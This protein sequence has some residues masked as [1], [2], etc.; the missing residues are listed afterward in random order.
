VL[1]VHE[2]TGTHVRNT[3]HRRVR[4]YTRHG[5][6]V[7]RT[8]LYRVQD[9]DPARV[10]CCCRTVT[11]SPWSARVRTDLLLPY[12]PRRRTVFG[13]ARSKNVV[14]TARGCVVTGNCRPR[15]PRRQPETGF[16]DLNRVRTKA[17]RKLN[18]SKRMKTKRSD[19]TF[20]ASVN[21]FS[22]SSVSG[23]GSRCARCVPAAN[24]VSG[25]HVFRLS[26]SATRK[27]L[28]NRYKVLTFFWS[29]TFFCTCYYHRFR[30]RNNLMKPPESPSKRL[31]RQ[32]AFFV[33]VVFFCWKFDSHNDLEKRPMRV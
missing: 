30:V 17:R 28:K 33:T 4:V 21:A 6:R 1:T 22:C 32:P 23:G 3:R 24:R 19:A 2:W 31:N 13:R 26:R 7:R 20:L 18:Y 16:N 25:R 27:S 15:A 8:R 29:W 9:T 12:M 5:R 14:V 10:F 11:S